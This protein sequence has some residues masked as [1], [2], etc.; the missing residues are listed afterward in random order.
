MRIR[1]MALSGALAASTLMAAPAMADE[2]QLPRPTQPL[3]WPRRRR[4]PMPS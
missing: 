2:R 1:I 3:P 4:R